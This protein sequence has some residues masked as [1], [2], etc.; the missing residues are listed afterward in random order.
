VEVGANT[1]LGG[2]S[3]LCEH[4]RRKELADRFFNA[5]VSTG[6]ANGEARWYGE[7]C[8]IKAAEWQFLTSAMNESAFQYGISTTRRCP[9]ADP[10][11][12][13][14]DSRRRAVHVL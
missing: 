1:I 5:E 3:T 2:L 14:Q 7:R 10:L 4:T 11:S 9:L 13:Q 8:R 6:N 12:R